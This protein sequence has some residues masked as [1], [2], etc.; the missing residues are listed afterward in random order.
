MAALIPLLY[1]LAIH[2]DELRY[3][4]AR[5][6]GPGGQNVNKVSTAVE[7]RFDL[8][9]SPSLPDAVKYRAASLA[10]Q[11]LADSGDIILF[12]DRFRTQAANRRDVTQRLLLSL[13]HI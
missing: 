13:I 5:A 8:A 11:R 10:G 9:R 6:S 3:R 2:P 1:G 4:F 12:G 7:L